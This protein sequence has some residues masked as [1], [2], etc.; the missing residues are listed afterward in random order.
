LEEF[1]A[2]QDDFQ[3]FLL[4]ETAQLVDLFSLLKRQPRQAG[5]RAPTHPEQHS[6]VPL[7]TSDDIL[8]HMLARHPQRQ[9]D[10]LS[11]SFLTT[12]HFRSSQIPA[13]AKVDLL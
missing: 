2:F 5:Q 13:I 1:D 6:E 9:P 3:L 12:S 11:F 10:K 8:A 4:R 7:E